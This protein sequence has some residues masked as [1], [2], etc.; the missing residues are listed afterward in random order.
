MKKTLLKWFV[1]LICCFVVST[2]VHEIGH[3]ISSYAV[4]VHVSTGF[5]K[6]GQIFFGTITIFRIVKHEYVDN[7][8]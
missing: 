7:L 1:V 3:G 2:F 5:N 6:V 8:D 4:G